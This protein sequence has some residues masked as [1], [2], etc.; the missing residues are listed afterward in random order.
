MYFL[1]EILEPVFRLILVNG[2][3]YENKNSEKP[4]PW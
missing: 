1:C 2:D 4:S 3:S